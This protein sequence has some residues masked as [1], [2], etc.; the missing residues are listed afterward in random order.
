MKYLYL[1]I[2]NEKIND[3]VKYGMKLSEYANKIL[4]TSTEKKGI[5]A[6]LSPSDCPDFSD[7]NFTCLKILTDNLNIYIYN[8]IFDNTDSL[9]DFLCDATDYNIGDYEDP[10]AIICST[11]LPE[12]IS[13]Y[14]KI[15][16][17]PLIVENSKDFFY[18]KSIQ[19]M[20]DNECFTSYELY[21]ML[22]ILGQQKKIFEISN[23]TD[24]IKIYK[25]KTTN[26]EYTKKNNF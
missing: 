12:N 1:F 3:A 15:L 21:Q 7:P 18:Q 8:K 20:L 24:K 5:A 13:I 19:E 25:S 10:I 2:E 9:D 11:I 16:D 14:N 23:I 17:T 6:Y 22:L 4:K 26:I